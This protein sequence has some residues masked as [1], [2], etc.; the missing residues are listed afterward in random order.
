MSDVPGSEAQPNNFLA[1]AECPHRF[2]YTVS[3]RLVAMDAHSKWPE[4]QGMG[5]TTAARKIE[6]LKKT[7][8]ANGF[9]E[10]LVTDNG[11]QLISEEFTQKK[12]ESSTHEVH[13]TIH[14]ASSSSV[15]SLKTALKAS[16]PT[17]CPWLKLPLDLLQLTAYHYKCRR[18]RCF[19][20][21]LSKQG[22]ICSD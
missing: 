17:V 6:V 5:S 13:P 15:Q 7:F 8:P 14:P 20:T 2:C 3:M 4:V 9:P 21:G 19:F 1:M 10:H 22:L 18:V 11:P 16:S 12:T